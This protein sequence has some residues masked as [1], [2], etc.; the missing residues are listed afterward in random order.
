MMKSVVCRFT[1]RPSTLPSL[2]LSWELSGIERRRPRGGALAGKGA[3]RG[4][5][6]T[7]A[8]GNVAAILTRLRHQN[9]ARLLL[10]FCC[11]CIICKLCEVVVPMT[12]MWQ[13]TGF[14]AVRWD[15]KSFDL[16]EMEAKI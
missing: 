12:F 16:F 4:K 10:W 2:L 6:A 15:S 13:K 7:N 8:Q 5:I 1:E 9:I 11:N 14:L 3:L